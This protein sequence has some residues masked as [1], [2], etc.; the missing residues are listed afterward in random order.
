MIHEGLITRNLPKRL[1]LQLGS[2]PFSHRVLILLE[3]KEKAYR[4][5][6]VN[7]NDKPDWL[8]G[9][10]REGTVPVLKDLETGAFLY[11]S[12]IISDYLE[13]KFPSSD[14]NV[15]S[16]GKM[17]DCPQPGRKLMP[18]FLDF[19]KGKRGKSSME[20]ELQEIENA[21]ENTN[22]PFL[23]GRNPNA[24]DVALA[25]RLYIARTG[26]KNLKQWNFAEEYPHIN[27]YIQAWLG[28]KS[29]H[30]TAS[31]DEDSIVDDLKAEFSGSYEV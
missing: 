24:Y 23:G 10:N 19:F 4:I 14:F 12:D 13:D 3:E 18:T 6:Y 20:K 30:N 11:D 1:F 15:P 21:L 7:V 5:V 2:C 25:P 31:Y 16:L 17:A 29:W 28:R 22:G 27:H 8:Y 26:C 9:V